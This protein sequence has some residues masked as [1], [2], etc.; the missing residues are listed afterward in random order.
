[1]LLQQLAEALQLP[2][3]AFTKLLEQPDHQGELASIM[4]LFQYRPAADGAVDDAPCPE[5]V[6]YTL[7]TLVPCAATPGLEVQHLRSSG[8]C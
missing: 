5:H 6:D 4:S 7:L 3:D 1:M 8:C 2:D